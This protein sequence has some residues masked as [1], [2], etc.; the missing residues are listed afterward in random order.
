MVESSPAPKLPRSLHVAVFALGLLWLLASRVGAQSAADGIARLLHAEPFTPLLARI[1]LLV[2]LFTGFTALNWVALRNGSVRSTSALPTRPTSGREW[3]KGAALGWALLLL[4][5][6]P[7]ALAGD[8]HPLFWFAPRA[9]GLALLA[10]VTLLLGALATEVAFRGFLFQRLIALI[11]PTSA[12]VVMAAIYAFVATSLQNVTPFSF[13]VSLMVAFAGSLA[14]LRTHGLWLGWGLRFGWI[15]SMG[16]LFGLPVQGS[17]DV[18]NVVAT[19]SAGPIWL[20]GGGFGPE[21]SV[22]A[23]LV[24]LGGL[25]ALYRLTRDYAWD[26][27]HEPI[28]AG[29]YAMDVPPPE[30]HTAMQAAPPPPP[31]V[32]ILGAVPVTSLLPRRPE[33]SVVEPVPPPPKA[34]PYTAVE[35]AVDSGTPAVNG[36]EAR[37]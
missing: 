13:G 16:V 27:T 12:T 5:I 20:T 29:G 7:A 19:Q 17:A 4:T 14:Y 24:L 36:D 25:F 2:L 37:S 8:L 11:G 21:G 15:A 23:G 35:G 33:S 34:V 9:W 18:A 31:L 10:L 26:Y 28:V 1:F 30:A 6:L 3:Q 32:Q 22:V